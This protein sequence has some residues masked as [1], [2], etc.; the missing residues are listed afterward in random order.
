MGRVAGN[1]E[2]GGSGKGVS[3]S[4]TCC[5]FFA[6]KSVIAREFLLKIDTSL[7]IATSGL[8]TNLLFENPLP[9]FPHLIFPKSSCIH[10]PLVSIH[11]IML[12]EFI[13]VRIQEIFL[14]NNVCNRARGYGLPSLLKLFYGLTYPLIKNSSYFQDLKSLSLCRICICSCAVPWIVLLSWRLWGRNIQPALQN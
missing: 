6:W 4:W 5:V 8:R 3:N 12:D 1:R 7:A 9:K 11:K 13:S 2:W 14:A 10:L